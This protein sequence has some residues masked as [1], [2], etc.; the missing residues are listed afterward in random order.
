MN[1]E[2]LMITEIPFKSHLYSDVSYAET[3]NSEH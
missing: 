2:L 3:I 1:H